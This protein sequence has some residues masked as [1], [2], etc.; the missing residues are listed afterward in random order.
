MRTYMAKPQEIQRRWYIIDAAG[1]S[2]GRVAS[3]AASLLRGSINRYIPPMWI[4][5]TT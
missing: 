5:A 2:L 4:Q 1:R 3:E